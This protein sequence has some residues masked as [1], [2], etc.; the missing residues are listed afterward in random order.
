MAVRTKETPGRRTTVTSSLN[1]ISTNQ[2]GNRVVVRG[3]GV[4]PFAPTPPLSTAGFRVYIYRRGAILAWIVI[5]SVHGAD[6]TA[7]VKL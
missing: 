7:E 6:I 2:L 5:L 3:E 1:E 4:T